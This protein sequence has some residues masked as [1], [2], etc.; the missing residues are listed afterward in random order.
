MSVSG[1]QGCDWAPTLRE[2]DAFIVDHAVAPS[3]RSTIV[4][5]VVVANAGKVSNT[6]RESVDGGRTWTPIGTSLLAGTLFSIDVDP[7][8]PQRLYAI[9]LDP[10]GGQFLISVDHGTTWTVRS[11][12]GIDANAIPYIA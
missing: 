8:D 5:A 12:P 3:N 6:L 2:T 9:I 10:N 1:D 4:A 7:N 11:I